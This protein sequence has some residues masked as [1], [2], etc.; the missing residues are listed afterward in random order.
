LEEQRHSSSEPEP[1]FAATLARLKKR[2]WWER[3]AFATVLVGVLGIWSYPTLFPGVWAISVQGRPLVAMRDRQAVQA[4]VQQV[5]QTYAAN[6]SGT[7]FSRE[8]RIVRANP[9]QVEITDAQTASEKLDA[10]WKQH[11]DQAI[12]YVDGNAVVSLP[13]EK[14]ATQALERVKADLSGGLENLTAAPTFKEKVEVRLEPT[15]EDISADEETAV[16]L[17]EGKEVEGDGSH[18]VAS[19]QNAWAIARQHQLSLQEL[20]QLNPGAN[21][22]RLRVGQQLKVNGAAQPLLTVIVEGSKTE[23]VPVPFETRMRSAP[24]MYLG[25]TL[26]VQAGQPGKARVTAHLRCENGKVVERTV[27]E[28][29][30]LDKPQTKVVA[31]GTKPRPKH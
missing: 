6:P 17:L 20:K 18:H 23:E 11:A 13:S 1:D 28:R 7:A 2:L 29:Q 15:T 26:Q 8:V 3:G 27:L 24:G 25:K 21:L 14:E 5:K 12:L 16:A 4:V 22:Q 19:G 9:A 31:V 10:A 30:L